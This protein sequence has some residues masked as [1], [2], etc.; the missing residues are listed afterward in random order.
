MSLKVEVD[1]EAIKIIEKMFSE[2]E[3]LPAISKKVGYSKSVVN[4]VILEN[5][6]K[7]GRKKCLVS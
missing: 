1:K 3:A 2:G 6:F 4:R 5:D 7:K